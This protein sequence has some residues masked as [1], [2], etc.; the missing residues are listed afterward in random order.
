MNMIVH[1][2]RQLI[3]ALPHL[4]GFHPDESMVIVAL[5]DDQ[6]LSIARLDWSID[7]I[8]IPE[9]ILG[10]LRTESKPA[11]VILAY[12]ESE[13][14]LESLLDLIPQASEFSLLD[15]L[16]I[17]DRHWRSL[18]CE[19]EQ[20]CP[21]TGHP[22]AE[23][24]GADA[25]FVFAGSAPFISREDLASRLSP[26]E[27]SSDDKAQRDKAI[28]SL[29]Q[30]FEYDLAQDA[31]EVEV[32][33]KYLARLM[34]MWPDAHSLDWSDSALL[35][36]VATNI[37]MRDGLL[38]KMFDHPELR[39]AM[40][41]TLM[42]AVGRASESDVAALATVLAGCAW[43]DGNGALAGVALE[44]ALTV[45]PGYSLARLLDRAIAHNVPPS[46]WTESLAAVSYDECLA[47]A[48]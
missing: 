41:T 2:P 9:A 30:E 5:N 12:T 28:A 47:G 20:C 31:L 44:C 24:L 29:K 4:L 34:A 22:L 39:L 38:R 17:A 26:I 8:P 40:R 37:Y 23:L 14:T 10:Q 16:Q 3:S 19:D 43:L 21:P 18:M 48:A 25:E 45:D 11:V 36:L 33:A 42:D 15:A 13:L 35:G 7:P 6:V 27:L 46:V 32:R 1:S